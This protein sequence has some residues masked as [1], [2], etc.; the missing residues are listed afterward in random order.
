MIE[1]DPEPAHTVVEDSGRELELWV[2]ATV[3][4]AQYQMEVE[5]VHFKDTLLFQTRVFK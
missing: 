5:P 4:Y 1:T 2:S 3:D